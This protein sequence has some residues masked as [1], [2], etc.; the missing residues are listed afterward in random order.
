MQAFYSPVQAGIFKTT[1]KHFAGSAPANRFARFNGTTDYASV[2]SFVYPTSEGTALIRCRAVSASPAAG[3]AGLMEMSPGIST[4]HYPYSDGFAYISSL[5]ATRVN[6]ITLSGSVDRTAWHWVI[7]RTNAGSGW[8][9]L[10]A[11]DAG[12]LYSVATAAHEA[13]SSSG[14]TIGTSNGSAMWEGDIDRFLLFSSRLNDAAIQAIIAGG[15]GAS[16][17]VRYEFSSDDG[18]VFADSSGNNRHATI[19]GSPIIIAA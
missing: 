8:E 1:P 10:Q 12:V 9:M 19:S 5:R 16:P 15:S 4:S 17:L 14:Q 2:G 13:F 3:K 6:S 18:D 7:V 11:S